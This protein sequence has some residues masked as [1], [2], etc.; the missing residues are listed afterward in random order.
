MVIDALRLLW[1]SW[2]PLTRSLSRRVGGGDLNGEVWNT[3]AKTRCAL[4]RTVIARTNF[5]CVVS[6]GRTYH[7]GCWDRQI[8]QQ[9]AMKKSA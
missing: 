3:P 7:A 9:A 4:C 2:R 8:R 6:K 1:G 5:Q